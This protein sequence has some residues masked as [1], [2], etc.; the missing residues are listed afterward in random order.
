MRD[1][2]DTIET[3][4]TGKGFTLPDAIENPAAYLAWLLREVDPEVPPHVWAEIEIQRERDR[5]ARL[6]AIAA[7]PDCPH[8]T[9]GGD[10]PTAAGVASCPFCRRDHAAAG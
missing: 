1:V 7:S 2:I 6:A 8:G 9:P 4:L 10:L 3:V 5:R